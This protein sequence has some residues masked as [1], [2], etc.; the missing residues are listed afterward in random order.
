TAEGLIV[1]LPEKKPCEHAFALKVLGGG[2]EPVPLPKA[3]TAISPGPDGK[4]VLAA[5]EAEIHGN[6]PQYERDGEKDQI[7]FWAD[8]NDFVSWDLKVAKP[9][10]YSVAI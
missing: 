7:G 5:S 1:T 6:T 8:P 9:G 3:E 10:P 2:L 4:I